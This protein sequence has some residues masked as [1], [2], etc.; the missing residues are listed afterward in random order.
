M[1]AV[2]KVGF[3]FILLA[4]LVLGTGCAKKWDQM[5]PQEIYEHGSEKL[6]NGNFSEAIEAYGA[7]I[8]LYPFSVYVSKAELGIADSY[9]AKHRYEEAIPAYEDYLNRHPTSEQ[10]PH[11]IYHLGMCYYERKLAVDRD[12][13]NTFSAERNFY[14]LVA[15]HPDSEFYAPAR[16]K[17]SQ[18][19]ADLAKRERYI[20]KFY[21]RDKEYY[22]SLRR[23]QRVIRNFPD[24]KYFAEALYYSGVCY[25]E[26]GEKDQAKR[27]VDLLLAKFPEG[28]Y[29]NKGKKLKEQ[30]D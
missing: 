22:A 10:V 13:A 14:E 3:L 9:F 30:L 4:A 27:Q 8:D 15:D 5:S 1:K 12:L 26:L 17:L 7:L 24:T 28:K 25:L 21:Y 29:A 11:V 19:R 23:Y 16:E 20:A 6:D 2:F 18:V